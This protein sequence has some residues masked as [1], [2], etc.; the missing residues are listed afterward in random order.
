MKSR[1]LIKEGNNE[2]CEHNFKTI[3]ETNCYMIRIIKEKCDKCGR[4]EENS[5]KK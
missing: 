4:I 1:L 2:N 3:S 5:L